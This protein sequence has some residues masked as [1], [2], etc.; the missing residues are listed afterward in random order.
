MDHWIKLHRKILDSQVFAHPTALKIWVWIL[1]KAGYSERYVP[2]KINRGSTTIRL[3]A[4]QF[5]FGRFTAE[6]ELNI[7]GSTIYKWIQ[8]FASEEFDMI[9]IKSN[10]HYTIVTI[11]NWEQYQS[12]ECNMVTTNEQP[13][14]S[15]VTAKEQPCNTNKNIR[16]LKYIKK[17]KNKDNVTLADLSFVDESFL[18]I[19]NKWL[20]FKDELRDP[21][22]TISGMQTQYAHLVKIS[23]NDP[24]VAE[25][26]VE[27]SIRKEWKGLFPLDDKENITPGEDPVQKIMNDIKRAR[28]Q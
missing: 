27:K 7:D 11:N 10:N 28:E 15:Q 6:D 25:K 26:I 21:Y 1:A 14:N 22:K 5:I 9:S 23:G 3:L 17:E 2:F 18:S 13:S 12:G 24:D 19:W 8:K 20:K 16:K 4:G